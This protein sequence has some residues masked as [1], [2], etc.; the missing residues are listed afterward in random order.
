MNPKSNPLI[1]FI[2]GTFCQDPKKIPP[3]VGL[4]LSDTVALF[5]TRPE[6]AEEV[7]LTKNKYF[8]KHPNVGDLVKRIAGDSIVFARNDLIWQQKRKALSAAM[9]KD[10]LKGMIEGMKGITLRV[11]K[12]EWTLEGGK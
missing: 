2:L 6:L 10:K 5:F 3:V 11:L 9:Y 1:D 12:E 4:C 8:D 7:L